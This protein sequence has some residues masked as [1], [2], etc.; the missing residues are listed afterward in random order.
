[1]AKQ[2]KNLD[3]GIILNPSS[4]PGDREGELWVDANSS[5]LK[6]FI[7]GIIKEFTTSNGSTAAS[8]S[9]DNITSGLLATNVQDAID[10][11]DGLI[12]AIYTPPVP[13]DPEFTSLVFIQA[14][15]PTEQ[16]QNIIPSIEVQ[17]K[18]QFGVDIEGSNSIV[19]T[20]S[21]GGVLSG[22]TTVGATLGSATFSDL[23]VDTPGTYT[24]TFTSGSISISSNLSISLTAPAPLEPTTMEMVTQPTDSLEDTAI[25]PPI[26]VQVKDQDGNNLLTS[27]IPITASL[28]TTGAEILSGT[29][30]VFTNSNGIASFGNLRVDTAGTFTLEF[31]S[32]T[33]PPIPS[34][35]F[36]ITL[37]AW[38]TSSVQDGTFFVSPDSIIKDSFPS[39]IN[40]N[41]NFLSTDILTGDSFVEFELQSD[42]SNLNTMGIHVGFSDSTINQTPFGYG[43]TNL[44]V[45]FYNGPHNH[46]YWVKQ[47]VSSGFVNTTSPQPVRGDIIRL[48]KVGN[49]VT[50]L[51]NGIKHGV[52]GITIGPSYNVSVTIETP[53]DGFINLTTGTVQPDLNTITWNIITSQPV[54]TTGNSVEL[55]LVDPTVAGT[56]HALIQSV[57]EITSGDFEINFDSF[58][59]EVGSEGDVI[60]GID[61]F[62][63]LNT[64]DSHAMLDF[65]FRSRTTPG[66]ALHVMEDGNTISIPVSYE[67]TD[68]LTIR[69]IGGV[70]TYHVNYYRVKTSTKPITYPVKLSIFLS[71]PIFGPI[72]PGDLPSR[73]QNITFKSLLVE[74]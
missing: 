25:T 18:D 12:D 58:V 1:M 16:N 14:P 38:E 55:T 27:G 49:Q 42:T 5:K 3:D 68:L 13:V 10:E 60:A 8:I 61:T 52:T 46:G 57:D 23:Q 64:D 56:P 36:E 9:Y 30:S 31:S 67:F 62:P 6:I 59:M 22:T 26:T 50:Y 63:Y 33:L 28:I 48:E 39:V 21:A 41:N 2:R 4:T 7:E 29:L 66:P 11:L 65:Y 53:G 19:A 44:S 17:M 70:V 15:T 71:N 54:A 35:I 37:P 40:Q 47:G 43:T 45:G 74:V 72:Q 32:G 73:I 51:V 24:I 69:S 20:L 34:N